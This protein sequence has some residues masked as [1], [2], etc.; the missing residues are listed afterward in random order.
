MYVIA[1]VT[2]NTGAVVADTLLAEG[3]PVRVI[4]R[5]AD[6]GAAWKARGAEVF[7]GSLEDPL[8]L[9]QALVGARGAYLL[10]PPDMTHPAQLARGRRIVEVFVEALT[11]TPIPHVVLLSSIGAELAEGTGPIRYLHYA[12]ERLGSLPQTRLTSLRAAYFMENLQSGFGPARDGGVLP[13]LFA[14]DTALEMVSTVDIGRTAAHA[15]RETPAKN[16]V[17]ELSGPEAYTYADGGGGAG[18]GAGWAVGRPRR[19]LPGDVAGHRPGRP[20]LPRPAPPRA[21]QGHA[22]R[23]RGRSA[24]PLTHADAPAARKNGKQYPNL[25]PRVRTGRPARPKPRSCRVCP[26]RA[27]LSGPRRPSGAPTEPARGPRP[28]RTASA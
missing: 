28:A 1:G 10:V 24:R 12:E 20:G 6:K 18:A 8:A 2:G 16:E 23:P 15:L 7:V 25:R 9:S 21:R 14:P 4:V 22:D 19:A 17:I 5:S 3:Q 27:A 13:A 11:R 26:R